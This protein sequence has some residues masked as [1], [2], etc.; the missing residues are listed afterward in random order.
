DPRA[1]DIKVSGRL[2]REAILPNERRPRLSHTVA[3]YRSRDDAEGR[4]AT[5]A[6]RHPARAPTQGAPPL[7]PPAR[8]RTIA[9]STTRHEDTQRSCSE[10]R[11]APPVPRRSTATTPSRE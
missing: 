8:C 10:S 4:S 6:R 5:R 2:Q 3:A 7:V 11:I 1:Q 9:V